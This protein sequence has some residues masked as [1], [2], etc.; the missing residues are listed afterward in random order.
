M[1][2]DRTNALTRLIKPIYIPSV[3]FS[4]GMGAVNPVLVFT[5]LAV[6]FD[7]AG[8]SAVLGVFG[9][10]GILL[11]PAIGR[12]ITNVGDRRALVLGG[13]LSVV[14][15]IGCLVSMGLGDS[16][17]SRVILTV[18]VVILGVAGNVWQLARQAYIS[19]SVPVEWR[20]RGLSTLGGMMRFG[21]LLGPLLA[22]AL[23]AVFWLQSVYLLHLAATLVAVSMVIVYAVPRPEIDVSDLSDTAK[24]RQVSELNKPTD[25][26][27]TAITSFSIN[28]LNVLRANK[29]VIIPLWGTFLGLEPHLVTATLAI[30][31]LLDATMFLLAGSIMDKRGRQWAL[32]P[33]LIIMPIG[34]LVMVAFPSVAGFIVG[35]A[36]LGF[37]NG[38]GAG[39][40]MTTAA[41]MSPA[42]NR[43]NFLGWWQAIVAIGTAAGP[44]VVSGVTHLFDLS[45]ALVATA[46]I[47]LVGAVWTIA[48]FKYAYARIGLNLQGQALVV[49]GEDLASDGRSEDVASDGEVVADDG[50]SE[51]L[52]DDGRSEAVETPNHP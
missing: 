31:S 13:S 51:D 28:C 40:N 17:A 48:L 29:N 36:L 5:A 2:I 21:A 32:L 22:T 6:G 15:V 27:S 11:S 10:V 33:S 30:T 35:S 24:I 52:A 46:G 34:I 14:A 49:E 18:A 3:I 25:K 43:A 23:L 50:R 12:L 39:I 37:G 7:D 45:A 1:K 44:F 38:F 47:G 41:D 26:V 42:K 8:S 9:L 4:T 16:L 19:D 20:A